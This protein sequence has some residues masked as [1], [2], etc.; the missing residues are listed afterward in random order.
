MSLTYKLFVAIIAFSILVLFSSCGE[1][2]QIQTPGPS[3]WK[4][5]QV[6]KP[7][8]INKKYSF[9]NQVQISQIPQQIDKTK[10]DSKLLKPT[11]WNSTCA[12]QFDLKWQ[13]YEEVDGF[14]E[15]IAIFKY[16]LKNLKFEEKT[17]INMGNEWHEIYGNSETPVMVKNDKTVENPMGEMLGDPRNYFIHD[18]SFIYMLPNGLAAKK[19]GK[20]FKKSFYMN[21]SADIGQYFFKGIRVEELAH[22]LFVMLPPLGIKEKYQWKTECEIPV[23]GDDNKKLLI[24]YESQRKNNTNYII[25]FNGQISFMKGKIRENNKVVQG[26]SYQI[27]GDAAVEGK[28]G[29]PLEISIREN[30]TWVQF[31]PFQAN[32]KPLNHQLLKY[33]VS[34][35]YKAQIK[36][37]K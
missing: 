2:D 1:V 21:N 7:N 24:H 11:F 22:K 36:N 13:G 17:K 6:I 15:P 8:E 32:S 26:W 27:V 31:I 35:L 23:S 20:I 12:G 30:V 28:T 37:E 14:K 16:K 29:M 9:V 25:K 10:T 19:D 5:H 3:E 34:N 18:K 4:G 33:S